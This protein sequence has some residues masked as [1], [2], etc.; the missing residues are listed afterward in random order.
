MTQNRTLARALGTI[1]LPAAIWAAGLGS[2]IAEELPAPSST[3][4]AAKIVQSQIVDG[5]SHLQISAPVRDISGEKSSEDERSFLVALPRGTTSYQLEIDG[6]SGSEI[7]APEGLMIMRGQPVLRVLTSGTNHQTVDL[8]ISHDGRWDSSNENHRLAS[9]AMQSALGSTMPRTLADGAGY[10]GAFLVIYAPA[11][12]NDIVPLVQWKTLKGYNVETV[13]TSV[14]GSSTAGIKEFIQTAYDTWDSPPEYVLLVGDVAD[15][16]TYNFYGNP[17]DQPYVQLEGDDWLMDAMI[18]RLPVENSTEAQSLINK[19]INYERHP[20]MANSP[21]QTRSL[22]VAGVYASATPG[23]TVDFCGERLTDMGFPQPGSVISP[24]MP[25]LMGADAVEATLNAGVGFVVY[26]GWAYGV[27]GWDPPLYTTNDIPAL[28]TNNMNPIVMSFVCLNGDYT[29]SSAC[30]GEVFVRQGSPS[31][32]GKGAVAFIGNGE[33]WSHTRYNDAMAISIFERIVDENMVDLGTLLNAGKVRFFDYF[34]NEVSAEEYEEESVEFYFHIYNL[35]GDPSMKFWR[36]LPREIEV[37][38]LASLPAGSNLLSVSVVT[39]AGAEPVVGAR[40]GVV[41]D[42]EVIGTGFTDDNGQVSLNLTPV[43]DNGDVSVTVSEADVIP[44][45]GT[46]TTGTASVFV[47][48]TSLEIDDSAGNDDQVANPGET[49]ALVPTVRNN[50]NT[51]SGAFDL[52]ILEVAGP[53]AIVGSPLA[54]SDLAG[55][56]ESQASGSVGLVIDQDAVDGAVVTLTMDAG[57]LGDQHDVSTVTMTVAAPVWEVVSFAASNGAPALRPGEQSDLSLTLRN[58]GS[59]ATSSAGMELT[60]LTA[61]A[62]LA[63]G[64][65]NLAACLPGE[66]V[67]ADAVFEV[68]ILDSTPTNSNL[69]F[70]LAVATS[71][72]YQAHTN[73]AVVVGPVDYSSPVGPDNYGY[74]AYDSADFDYPASRPVY[75]WTDISTEMGGLG[76]KMDFPIDNRVVWI[77]VDLPFIFRYYGQEYTQIR[78]SDNGWISFDTGD[79]F[80]FYNWPIPSQHGVEALVAPFW[81]N[82][83]PVPPL[84]GEPN[85]NGIPADG[86]YTYYDDLTDVFIVEWSRLPHYKPEILGFQTFQVALLNPTIYPTASGDGEMLFQYRQ[87]NNNDNLRMYATVGIES[88]GGTDGLQLSYSNINAP[89]MAPLQSGLAVRVTTAPPVRVPFALTSMTAETTGGMVTLQWDT[90]DNRPVIGW[91]VDR[92]EAGQ[93]M[94]MTQAPLPGSIRRTTFA[95]NDEDVDARYLLTA[96]HPYGVSSEPGEVSGQNASSIRFALHPA[97]PNPTRG[98]TNIR[99]ALPRQTHVNLRVYDVAGRLVRTLL[100]GEVGAGEGVKIWDGRNDRGG[101]AAGG[102]YFYRLETGE[103]TLTR[104]MILVR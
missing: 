18:G 73:L 60:L 68:E 51:S 86:I 93:R 24:P 98:S 58:T 81:D 56:A 45:E 19:I 65:A 72:G 33:H 100:S 67:T 38:H 63:G 59:A 31:E 104:K 94:R 26:R 4:N 99:F 79:D 8:T 13:S 48:V 96:L 42:G 102:V 39:T 82:L 32:P 12:A 78:I 41:Q 28:D 70:D 85:V 50:G 75:S 80:N 97:H 91:H 35:L 90:A 36:Q 7:S 52:E 87:I 21:W 64:F 47:T 14:T 49:L 83:N 40:V 10:G 22:M 27:G 5:Q 61:G 95:V 16:P 46:I 74:Y 77:V 69:T 34:P 23:Y 2:G 11:F 89:G 71:E 55:G 103:Q 9:S 57:R 6:P 54:M 44:Y 76:T 29:S 30:F 53:A 88:P 20:E 43:T 17:S 101:Q 15:I 92:V 66:T 25:S 1:L 62:T 37:S 3:E 84:D